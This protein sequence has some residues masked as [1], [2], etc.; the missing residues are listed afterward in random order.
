MYMPHQFQQA[1]GQETMS[2]AARREADEQ[3]GELAAALARA[4][5][6]AGRDRVPRRW[7]GRGGRRAP[8]WFLPTGPIVA[9]RNPDAN[10]GC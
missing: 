10:H 1:L 8:Q 9:F 6:R 5:R 4:S 7:R 3:L 2:A